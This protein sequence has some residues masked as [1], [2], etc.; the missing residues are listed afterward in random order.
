MPRQGPPPFEDRA[1]DHQLDLLADAARAGERYQLAQ[2]RRNHAV[3][4]ALDVGVPV[5]VLVEQACMPQKTIRRLRDGLPVYGSDIEPLC[6]L[7]NPK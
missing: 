5:R 2:K 6:N 1:N 4:A 3:K 7:P